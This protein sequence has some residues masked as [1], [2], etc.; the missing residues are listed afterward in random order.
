MKTSNIVQLMLLICCGSILPTVQFG[1]F[2]CFM[3]NIEWTS[4]INK[5]R[6][7]LIINLLLLEFICIYTYRLLIHS[8]IPE[9]RKVTP[10]EEINTLFMLFMLLFSFILPLHCWHCVCLLSGSMRWNSLEEKGLELVGPREKRPWPSSI[11]RSRYRCF[12]FCCCCCCLC[13]LLLWTSSG[14][15]NLFLHTCK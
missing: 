12:F 14:K 9:E 2:L 4:E 5:R 13:V 10:R 7:Y 3:H 15:T 8:I 1:I 11:L 6:P